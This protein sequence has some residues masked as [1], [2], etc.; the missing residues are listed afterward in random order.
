M[1]KDIV[2]GG[3]GPTST[4]VEW[5]TTEM[6]LN[7]E[8]MKKF[9]EELPRMVGV[10]NGWWVLSVNNTIEEFSGQNCLMLFSPKL[11]SLMPPFP[12]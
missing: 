2:I 12:N 7:L 9:L 6:M 10:N 4:M 3:I 1:S 5:V 8:V 11:Y